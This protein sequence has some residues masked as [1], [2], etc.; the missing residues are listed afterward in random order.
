MCHAQD[1]VDHMP[2]PRLELYGNSLFVLGV[3]NFMVKPCRNYI[4]S[5]YK[6][7]HEK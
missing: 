4:G 3:E 2:Y 7:I 6:P 5:T 1:Y